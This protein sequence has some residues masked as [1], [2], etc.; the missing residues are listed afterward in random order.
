MNTWHELAWNALLTLCVAAV[1]VLVV[2]FG[3]LLS[4]LNGR[5]EAAAQHRRVTDH[6]DMVARLLDLCRT[7]VLDATT[8]AVQT[9]VQDAKAAGTWS[10]QLAQQ[11]KGDVLMAVR[12][13]LGPDAVA[14]A[15]D[16]KLDLVAI[17][18]DMVES[19]VFRLARLKP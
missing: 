8:A 16:L 11:V 12:A 3:R 19:S 9:L 18:D 17:L 2:R 6:V 1:P 13:K 5:L 14:I 4:S 10:P 7:L 15:G